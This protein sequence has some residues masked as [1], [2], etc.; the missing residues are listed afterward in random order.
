MNLCNNARDAMPDGGRLVISARQKGRQ[1]QVEISDTGEGMD[2]EAASKCFDPFFTTK[3]LGKGTGLGLSTT[4]GII[5]SHDGLITVDSQPER[6]TTFKILF[7]P[8][9]PAEQGR[10]ECGTEIPCGNGELI[11][12]VD[13]EPEIR[14]AMQG[15]L[16]YLG[17]RAEF[18]SNGI[19]GLEKYRSKK[20]DAVLM[21]MNMPV[22]GGVACIEE[23]LNHDPGANISIFSGY[24][25]DAADNLSPD[26]RAAIKDFL[27]KPIGLE[28]L[29]ALLAKMLKKENS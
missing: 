10:Q 1:V 9:P 11:L 13:D 6:G 7:S 21:D 18:A 4:Y 23:I 20:P 27:P 16:K 17:Y 8:A 19:E 14:N 15:L 5:N 12:V 25:Q 2:K 28:A 24:N 3:P 26:A 29:S 22:M